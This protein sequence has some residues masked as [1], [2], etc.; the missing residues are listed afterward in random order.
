MIHDLKIWPRFFEA[1]DDESKRFEIRENDRDFQV[2]DALRL[3]EF[4]PATGVTHPH[5][6][7]REMKVEVTFITDFGMKEG[8]VA[9]SIRKENS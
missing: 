2:G 8:F 5:Y 3:R 1:V 6:T 9:M 7:G 4:L